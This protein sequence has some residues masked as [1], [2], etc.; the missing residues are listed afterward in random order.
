M[1]GYYSQQHTDLREDM[2]KFRFVD[3]DLDGSHEIFYE[4]FIGGEPTGTIIFK[5]NLLGKFEEIFERMGVIKSLWRNT[6][7]GPLLMETLL[8]P[9]CMGTTY[10]KET[11][12]YLN[13]DFDLLEKVNWII[14]TTIP[15]EL[16]NPVKFKVL[17][18]PYTLRSSPE[19]KEDNILTAYKTG[20]F[21]YAL[22][23]RVDETGR[24]WWFVFMLNNRFP[25]DKTFYD[26]AY[27]DHYYS[28]GWMSSR[29]VEITT[30]Q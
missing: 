6:I 29:Y 7:D 25:S 11:W 13:S 30:S 24:V 4:G 16:G 5:R 10:T 23:E 21:G 14:G 3:L 27:E 28:I 19:I 12:A 8:R 20:D 2:D 26:Y 1:S 15:E 22:A 17:N 9:C 18:D